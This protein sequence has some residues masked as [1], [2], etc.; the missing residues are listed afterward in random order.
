MP[1]RS[2][3][4]SR[5]L[6]FTLAALLL[7]ASGAQAQIGLLFTGAG[8]VNRSMGGAA[9]ATALDSIGALF[10]NP[11]TLSGLAR[12]ELS[13]G[14]ELLAPQERLTSS[15]AGGALGPTGPAFPLTGSDRGDVGVF[16]LPSVGL[17]YRPDDSDW[18]FGLGVFEVAGFGV[19]Y[20]ASTFNPVLT[21]QPPRGVGLGSIYSELQVLEIAPA[22]SYQLTP[23]LSVGF[24]PLV[25]LANLHA[26][27][28]VITSPDATSGYAT[29][30][31][32]THSRFSWGGGFQ[33]GAYYTFDESWRLGAS[34]QSPRWFE[35]FQFQSTSG[36]GQ[37]RNFTFST[38]LPMVVSVGGAY[39]G[40]ERWLL[41]ADVRYV[42]FGAARGLRQSGFD[43]TGAVRGLGWRS[44]WALSLGSQYQL[45]DT[46][47]LR[48]GYSYN[49]SP[50]DGANAFFN[51]AAPTI[52]EHTIYLGASWNVTESLSLSLAYAH[53]FQNSVSGPFVT[54]FGSLPGTSVTSI[55]S[56]DTFLFG[57]TVRFGRGC[58]D[59]AQ[60]A[61]E[62]A[63]VQ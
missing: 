63:E 62:G 51:V 42:D 30:P 37:P 8:P 11:A 5:G 15:I 6:A 24:G 28:A 41:A 52:L 2:W 12:P 45:S 32:G 25:T 38:D 7:G 39:A 22:L 36:S 29:Y 59:A 18:T 33:A 27:P 4:E 19:N 58:K 26:D 49:Q 23:H 50:I 47:S 21:P 56:A 61:A 31:P 20:P 14:V 1:R 34:V 35:H 60:P 53:A 57:A 54:P 44:V 10:W 46:I 43:P 55:V 16:P 13:F 9:T 17:S 40:F 48:A 3:T